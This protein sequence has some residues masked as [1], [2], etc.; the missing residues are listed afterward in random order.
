MIQI[1]PNTGELL[2]NVT[3][4]ASLVTSVAFGGRRLGI[5]Y[6]GTA[7]NDNLTLLEPLGGSVFEVRGLNA[8][9]VPEDEAA[10]NSFCKPFYF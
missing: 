10:V 8:N 9:G 1:N 6:V 4:P 3:I 7:R 2:Q 5:L